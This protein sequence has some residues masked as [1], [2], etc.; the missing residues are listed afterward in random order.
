MSD[1]QC[2]C[3]IDYFVPMAML[4]SHEAIAERSREYEDYDDP[5]SHE[6]AAAV[7]PQEE[8]EDY[9][10]ATQHSRA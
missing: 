1:P 2:I 9:G 3:D 6:A 10:E 5:I 7:A 8:F 4:S